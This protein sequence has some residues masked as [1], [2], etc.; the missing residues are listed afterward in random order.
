M[1]DQ[2]EYR[3]H[4]CGALGVKLW[5][6]YQT[7]ASVSELLCMRCC[8]SKQAR[9]LDG[10]WI[11]NRCPAVLTAER[12]TFWG[13]TSVPEDRLLWWMNL[14]DVIPMGRSI[15]DWGKVLGVDR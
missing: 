3:C 4:G 8:E 13:F 1:S 10:V 12:D 9:K 14:A 5:R 15:P 11:G 6:Q 7:F 2:L